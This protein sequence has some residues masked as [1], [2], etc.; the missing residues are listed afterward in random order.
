MIDIFVALVVTWIAVTLV[1]HASWLILGKCVNM[2]TDSK[3]QTGDNL[4]SRSSI[5]KSVI[6]S[7]HEKGQIDSSTVKE[8]VSA[9]N[10]SESW[11]QLNL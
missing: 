5:A 7:L 4:K 1:G 2:F 6:Q 9:I 8:V 11:S 10:Q 3:E